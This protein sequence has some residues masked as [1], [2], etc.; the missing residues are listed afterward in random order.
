MD[1]LKQI[2][3][4]LTMMGAKPTTTTDNSGNVYIKVNA[5]KIGEKRAE[6]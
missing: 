5:P 2:T 3:N 1:I 4:T 6:K